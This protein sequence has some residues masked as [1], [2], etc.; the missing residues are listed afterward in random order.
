MRITKVEPIVLQVPLTNPVVTSF[1]MMTSRTCVLVRVE[2][3]T[4]QQG[5]GE[6]WNN[7]PSWGVYEKVATLKYGIAPLVVGE[8]P[9]DIRRIHQKLRNTYTVMGL[10]WGAIGPIYHSMSGVDMAIWDL[11]GKHV[12]R[13]VAH[14][15][16]GVVHE[17]VQVY[18][19][20]LGPGSFEEFVEQHLEVGITAF[21]LKVGRDEQQDIANIRRMRELLPKQAKLMIDANQAWDERTAVQRIQRYQEFEL[22]WVEEPLQCD[23][24]EGMAR[25]REQVGV[26][27]A[28][29][30][31]VYGQ[32]QTRKVLE[33]RAVDIIQPDLSKQ[34]GFSG[35]LQM[36]E[37]AASWDV[38]YAPHFLG[39]AVCL[40][41][42]IQFV[43]SIPGAVI[44]ELDANP[45][46]FRERLFTQ[47]ITVSKGEISLPRLP[48]LGFELDEEFVEFY[49]I[50]LEH[51]SL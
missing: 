12:G 22:T 35:C 46:P 9:R 15:L 31:N 16:G 38:P 8:D 36:V 6:I 47:T 51:M 43:A 4:G 48:G 21:K 37:M 17:S 19:S 32:R 45:N 27:I 10:Q 14:L 25:V 44:L 33:Q 39:G 18:A 7:F 49:R 40:A 1:G 28:F 30:E 24:I 29:G 34:G 11:L 2:A 5:I 41:A 26:P 13:S 20:G 23:D 3:D 50:P 42:S